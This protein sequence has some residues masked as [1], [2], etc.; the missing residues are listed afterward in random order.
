MF[1]CPKSKLF[2]S[3][4]PSYPSLSCFVEHCALLKLSC[5]TKEINLLKNFQTPYLSHLL[6][7]AEK[8][9]LN[10]LRFKTWHFY[11]H[12]WMIFFCGFVFHPKTVDSIHH[13]WDQF[14]KF[15]MLYENP[16]LFL[17]WLQCRLESSEWQLFPL[18]LSGDTGKAFKW[19]QYVYL[20]RYHKGPKG[21]NV[22]RWV[23]CDTFRFAFISISHQ[24][25][26]IKAWLKE[27]RDTLYSSKKWHPLWGKKSKN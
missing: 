9:L 24:S 11:M 16:A 6:A 13:M 22:G 25:E 10:I 27:S 3:R 18:T 4:I 2:T 23:V 26:K 7:A 20:G 19:G 8:I 12:S 1:F 15:Y 5:R 14:L 21:H 17:E